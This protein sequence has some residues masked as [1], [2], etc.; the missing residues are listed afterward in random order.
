MT[1]LVSAAYNSADL[2][3][4][5]SAVAEQRDPGFQCR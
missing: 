5:L 2:A 4:G 3:E 1:T